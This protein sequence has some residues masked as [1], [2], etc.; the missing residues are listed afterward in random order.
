VTARVARGQPKLP[1]IGKRR[2]HRVGGNI[3][4]QASCLR[5]FSNQS[6]A[7]PTRANSEINNLATAILHHTFMDKRQNSIDQRFGVGTRLERGRAD[8]FN[9]RP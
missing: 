9:E 2:C 1:G 3:D 7:D 4:T 8:S 6:Q 5:A